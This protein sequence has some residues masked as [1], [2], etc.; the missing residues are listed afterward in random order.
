MENK[1]KSKA[2]KSKAKKSKAKKSKA[3][4]AK[5]KSSGV[6]KVIGRGPGG[7]LSR[8]ERHQLRRAGLSDAALSSSAAADPAP[9][10]SL[11]LCLPL[12]RL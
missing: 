1:K 4:K 9:T 10:P 7:N 3:K 2:K 5:N 11:L 12:G 8:A 6:T